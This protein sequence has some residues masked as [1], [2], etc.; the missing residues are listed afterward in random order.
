M[1][2]RPPLFCMN[3]E[4]AARALSEDKNLSIRW[5]SKLPPGMGAGYSF[6]TNVIFLPAVDER[7]LTKKFARVIR[8]YS[9]HERLHHSLSDGKAVEDSTKGGPALKTI[10]NVLEDVRIELNSNDRYIGD[11]QDL[12]W[13]RNEENKKLEEDIVKEGVIEDNRLGAVIACIQNNMFGLPDYHEKLPDDLRKLFDAGIKIINDGRF[14]KSKKQKRKGTKICLDIAK[15]LIKVWKNEMI[16]I[17]TPGESREGEGGEGEES[18]GEGGESGEE[19][20]PKDMKPGN[21]YTVKP[22]K[23]PSKEKGDKENSKSNDSQKNKEK[24]EKTEWEKM[25]EDLKKQMG[26]KDSAFESDPLKKAVEKILE[27][28]KKESYSD[29]KDEKVHASNHSDPVKFDSPTPYTIRKELKVATKNQGGY[30]DLRK[31]IHPKFNY[32]KSRLARYLL[33][34]TNTDTQFD[35]ENGELDRFS[36]GKLVSGSKKIFS[37]TKEGRSM[38]TAVQLVIDLSGS[39]IGSKNNLAAQV[40]CLFAE[41]LHSIR[42]PFEVIGYNTSGGS[43]Y[44]NDCKEVV[45][46]WVFKYFSEKYPT[47]K[48]RMGSLAHSAGGCNIDHEVIQWGAERL[49]QR[50]EQK[51]VQIVL[52]DGYPNAATPSFNHFIRKQLKIVNQQI[53]RSGIEQFCFGIESGDWQLY[54][55]NYRQINNLNDLMGESLKVLGKFLTNGANN[56]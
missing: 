30:H 51:K 56:V 24:K 10:M 41:I 22:S 12:S 17:Q 1:N 21:T 13:H 32:I 33:A 14:E 11:R 43:Y 31:H 5:C 23:N 35:L 15:E 3:T 38:S 49:W 19:I 39:M 34:L 45:N 16:T 4:I 40:A 42:V 53:R 7:T 20:D 52:C 46:H 44:G 28:A 50:T 54:Y 48:F 36:F 2:R 9:G 29:D 55:K 47:I 26:K 25:E 27:K 6:K 18:E 37:E 8:S